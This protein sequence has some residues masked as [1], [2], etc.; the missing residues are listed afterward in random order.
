MDE[1]LKTPILSGDSSGVVVKLPAPKIVD[2]KFY[3]LQGLYADLDSKGW[4]TT[5]RNFRASVFHLS[6]HAG[7][8]DF[9]AYAHWA[10]AKDVSAATFAVS[11]VEDVHI[12]TEAK[13]KWAGVLADLAHAS[14]VSALRLGDPDEIEDPPM[15]V[16]AKLLLGSAGVFRSSGNKLLRQED[17]QVATIDERVRIGVEE[18]VK[19]KSPDSRVLL[20]KAAEEISRP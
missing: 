4:E 12:I 15:R 8:S 5:W 6:L 14:Y 7:F 16:A 9:R 2:D 20:T 18:Y 19:R 1:G 3:Q 10:K 11:L 17:V 13:L